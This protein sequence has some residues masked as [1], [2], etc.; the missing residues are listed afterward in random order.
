MY[1]IFMLSSYWKKLRIGI[2]KRRKIGTE[3]LRGKE[4]LRK[5]KER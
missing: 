2:K 3:E 5:K 1:L 4:R